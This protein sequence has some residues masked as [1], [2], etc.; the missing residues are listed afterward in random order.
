MKPAGSINN[1]GKVHRSFV[2]Q[3]RPPQDDRFVMDLAQGFARATLLHRYGQQ[4]CPTD[5]VIQ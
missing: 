2:G 1:V 5:Y 3:K 4:L